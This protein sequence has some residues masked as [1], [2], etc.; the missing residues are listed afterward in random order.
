MQKPLTDAAQLE[1]YRDYLSLLARLQ[2]QPRL[3][4]KLG[5]SDIVQQTLMKASQNLGEYRGRS[6]AELPVG[7]GAS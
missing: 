4:S 7:C 5:A 6:D 2:L 1:R 3:R